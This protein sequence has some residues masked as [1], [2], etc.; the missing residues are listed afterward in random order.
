MGES[1]EGMAGARW[2]ISGTS[3]PVRGFTTHGWL[4]RTGGWDPINTSRLHF[5]SLCHSP[6]SLYTLQIHVPASLLPASSLPIAF[7]SY[8][9]SIIRLLLIP[10]P[11]C[12]NH[13]PKSTSSLSHFSLLASHLLS[14]YPTN[15]FPLSLLTL[16][17]TS[18]SSSLHTP[19]STSRPRNTQQINAEGRSAM[20]YFPSR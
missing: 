16:A 8:F 14:S 20:K 7:S 3:N 10:L 19:A 11:P 6:S 1:D 13:T 17:S 4:K 12:H 18:P 9:T 2:A 15:L 5:P